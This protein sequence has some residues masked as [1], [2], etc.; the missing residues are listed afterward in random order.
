VK[1]S[2]FRQGSWLQDHGRRTALI[3][4]PWDQAIVAT[5]LVWIGQWVRRTT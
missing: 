4:S 2:A 1:H 3:L 5:K